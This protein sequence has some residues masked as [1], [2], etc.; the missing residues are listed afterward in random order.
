[1]AWMLRRSL[2]PCFLLA[3]LFLPA[4]CSADAGGTAAEPLARALKKVPQPHKGVAGETNED[5][6]APIRWWFRQRSYPAG[7]I[8]KNAYADARAAFAKLAAPK[9]KGARSP[10]AS[11]LKWSLIGP[12]PLGTTSPN[13]NWTPAAGRLGAL[14]IDP[15]NKNTLYAGGALGG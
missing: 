3:P 6:A 4:A 7:T 12:S 9:P 1:G 13:P 14:A 10:R 8:P 11:T 15:S 2:Y 5:R